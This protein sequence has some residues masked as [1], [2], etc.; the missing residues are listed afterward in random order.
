MENKIWEK[1]L[2]IERDKKA[3]ILFVVESGSRAWGFASLESDYNIRFIYKQ[4]QDYWTMLIYKITFL[5]NKIIKLLT[6]KS[7]S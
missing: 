4:E 3:K 7:I 6:L 5:W 2:Q 1:L